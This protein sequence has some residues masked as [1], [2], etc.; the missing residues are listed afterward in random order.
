[1]ILL[2]G[3]AEVTGPLPLTDGGMLRGSV[4]HPPSALADKWPHYG[5]A[6]HVFL[7][8]RT[9]WW[10]LAPRGTSAFELC[11]VFW[12]SESFLF[13]A[14]GSHLVSK[15]ISTRLKYSHCTETHCVIWCLYTSS[16][17]EHLLLLL[18]I[19]SNILTSIKSQ[20]PS[21]ML[22]KAISHRKP[23]STYPR[24]I[25]HPSPN[26]SNWFPNPKSQGHVLPLISFSAEEFEQITS[27][28]V[29]R[30]PMG[31]GPRRI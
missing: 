13:L 17:W 2:A 1:M 5:S 7:I 12:L 6:G 23:A 18:S 27:I 19:K 28:C 8:H 3:L 4:A 9:E 22:F 10:R 16:L 21:N 11:Q 20:Y 25:F 26:S 15:T 14:H 31:G 30:S 29:W 24:N